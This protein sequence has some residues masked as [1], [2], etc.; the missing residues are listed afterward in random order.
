[1]STVD[2]VAVRREQARRSA[3]PGR[4]GAPLGFGTWAALAGYGGLW[5]LCG[6]GAADA[7]SYPVASAYLTEDRYPVND[8]PA[9]LWAL[10]GG[11]IAAL[12]LGP[13]G[14]GRCTARRAT[15]YGPLYA[16]GFA[17]LGGAAGLLYGARQRWVRPPREGEFVDA[18]G[19]V[20]G[21]W[22]G[23]PW[24]VW[25]AQ[26]WVP[27]L[28]LVVLVLRWVR[29]VRGHRARQRREARAW[30]VIRTGRRVSGEVT[31][32]SGT[33]VERDGRPQLDVVVRLTDQEG[34]GRWVTKRAHFGADADGGRLP[35]AGDRAVVWFDPLAP[36]DQRAIPVALCDRR[37]DVEES[38][39]RGELPYL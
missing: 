38:L 9:F 35:R 32:V 36:G 5:A 4:E 17:H 19:V 7:A 14:R 21:S 22:G 27:A 3:A 13:S 2:P 1:M 30:E 28:L 23:G 20:V 10:F 29:A 8:T 26:W 31:D 11:L 12:V 6:F 16:A 24:I 18:A 39:R 33:G 37:G 34:R 15:H 25:T